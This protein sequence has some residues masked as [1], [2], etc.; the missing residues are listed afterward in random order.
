MRNE[1]CAYE[2][3]VAAARRSG[4]WNEELEEHYRDCPSCREAGQV[5]E[6]VSSLAIPLNKTPLPDPDLL[7]IRARISAREKA[8]NRLLWTSTFRQTVQHGFVSA[9]AAWLV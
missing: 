6:W 1:T 7:W 4:N 9:G 3:A 2:T 5:S 8:A